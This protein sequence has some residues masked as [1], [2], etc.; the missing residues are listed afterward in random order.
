MDNEIKILRKSIGINLIVWGF[1]IFFYVIT[2]PPSQ[3]IFVGIDIFFAGIG[4]LI[5]TFGFIFF[6]V[7]L[8]RT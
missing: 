7:Y 4:L 3:S 6:G 1:I 8:L 5:T 2:S